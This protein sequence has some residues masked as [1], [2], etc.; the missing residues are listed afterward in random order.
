[1]PS[2]IIERIILQLLTLFL[3]H[4]N[5]KA[6]FQQEKEWKETGRATKSDLKN[7]NMATAVQIETEIRKEQH[8]REKAWKETKT[9]TIKS[10]EDVNMAKAAFG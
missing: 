9:A 3:G 5:R 6:Q 2:T 7:V 4:D 8:E 10:N 1:M